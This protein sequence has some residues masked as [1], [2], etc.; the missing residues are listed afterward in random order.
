M[1]NLKGAKKSRYV[2]TSIMVNDGQIC[3]ELLLSFGPKIITTQSNGTRGTVASNFVLRNF[4]KL[5]C[6][7]P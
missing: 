4:L 5:L 7:I 3:P 2:R 6:I 1:I